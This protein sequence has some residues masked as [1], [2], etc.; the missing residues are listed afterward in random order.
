MLKDVGIEVPK[1]IGGMHIMFV[2][3]YHPLPG[4]NP[5][6]YAVVIETNR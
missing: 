2:A 5:R 3:C 6:E 4:S 1:S